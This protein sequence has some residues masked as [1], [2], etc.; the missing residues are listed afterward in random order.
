M[1][2]QRK[3]PI[4]SSERRRLLVLASAVSLTNAR[5]AFPKDWVKPIISSVLLPAH[6]QT[7]E[8]TATLENVAGCYYFGDSS[9]I[10]VY[11]SG[12]VEVRIPNA[13]P[14]NDD[15]MDEDGFF[16]LCDSTPA[17]PV[18]RVCLWGTYIPNSNELSGEYGDAIGRK[19]FTAVAGDCPGSV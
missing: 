1:A 17:N 13:F 3:S 14:L 16:V 10:I 12:L 18:F 4:P 5:A 11:E 19:P 2:S 9:V 7:S 6:A 8:T 15:Y